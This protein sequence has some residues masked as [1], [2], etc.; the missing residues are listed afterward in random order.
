MTV[1]HERISD[2]KD[3]NW[4]RVEPV[5]SR[6]VASWGP[7]ESCEDHPGARAVMDSDLITCESCGAVLQVVMHH[8]A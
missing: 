7:F 6:V 2:V 4:T 1:V 5:E 3:T 8:D